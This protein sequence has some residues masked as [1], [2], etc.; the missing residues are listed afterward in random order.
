MKAKVKGNHL[1][2]LSYNEEHYKDV[3]ELS[4]VSKQF[5]KYETKLPVNEFIKNRIFD[6]KEDPNLFHIALKKPPD[7]SKRFLH[8]K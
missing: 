7:S 1:H 2:H 8:P 3:I 6:T 4:F 5:Y